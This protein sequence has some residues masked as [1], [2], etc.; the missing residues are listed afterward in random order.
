M[1]RG[2]VKKRGLLEFLDCLEEEFLQ[3]ADSDE[4]HGDTDED[5]ISEA[6]AINQSSEKK[7]FISHS[8]NGLLHCA[9]I[10]L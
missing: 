7:K 1:C 3:I 2:K 10:L 9:L 5:D 4:N 8:N 6:M